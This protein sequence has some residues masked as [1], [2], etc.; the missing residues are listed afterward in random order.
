M[1]EE[2]HHK[3]AELARRVKKESRLQKELEDV[4]TERKHDHTSWQKAKK[5]LKEQLLA[6][7]VAKES[8]LKQ[9]AEVSRKLT[10]SS[11]RAEGEREV[12]ADM[13]TCHSE[14]QR[15]EG[16]VRREI[17]ERRELE[18]E[19]GRW[20]TERDRMER[21]CKEAL[22]KEEAAEQRWQEER[23]GKEACEQEGEELRR[24]VG[25]LS[26]ELKASQDQLQRE[27]EGKAEKERNMEETLSHLQQELAKRA[28]QVRHLVYIKLNSLCI[29]LS[30]QINFHYIHWGTKLIFNN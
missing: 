4:R 20:R 3:D 28:Q 2:L 26:E 27:M 10:L 22:T 29:C 19:A 18:A 21:R 11:V 24:E 25:R 9:L 15:L 14:I 30:V 17:E 1:G 13:E 12:R 8:L 23:A 7:E 6:S 16:V 5:E